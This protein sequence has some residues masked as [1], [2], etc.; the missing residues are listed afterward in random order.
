LCKKLAPGEIIFQC[1][2]SPFRCGIELSTTLDE[3]RRPPVS[4]FHSFHVLH[5]AG[6]TFCVAAPTI[7]E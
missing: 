2:V 6:L 3:W 5:L 4:S 7:R 1:K